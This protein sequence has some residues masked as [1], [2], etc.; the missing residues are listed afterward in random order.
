MPE[1]WRACGATQGFFHANC[2]PGS[3]SSPPGVSSHTVMRNGARCGTV[4]PIQECA[5]AALAHGLCRRPRRGV[6][7]APPL[8]VEAR[9]GGAAE[10]WPSIR[11][12]LSCRTGFNFSGSTGTGCD[13][14]F[15]E[16]RYLDF[17]PHIHALVSDGLFVRPS[18]N[19]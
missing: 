6:Q 2:L 7:P 15:M 3:I 12:I 14:G 11:S 1:A 16:P 10:C 13:A 8:P 19:P 4:S 5:A 17:H 9:G 18:D